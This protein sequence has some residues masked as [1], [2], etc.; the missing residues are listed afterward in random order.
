MRIRDPTKDIISINILQGY[1]YLIGLHY[2]GVCMGYPYPNFCF[3]PVFWGP[4]AGTSCSGGRT[5]LISSMGLLQAEIRKVRGPFWGPFYK[6]AV[7]YWGL[8]QGP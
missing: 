3:C 5:R 4:T 7:V 8:K 6:G 1:P 2:K